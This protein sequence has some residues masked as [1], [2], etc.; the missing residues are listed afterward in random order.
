M[1]IWGGIECTINRVGDQYFNQL[2]YQGHYQ[3]KGDLQLLA[4]LG[5]KKLRYPVLWEKH[6]S[7]S[8]VL[9]WGETEENLIELKARGIEVIAGLVHHGS[10]PE[11]AKINDN[12]FAEKL[13]EFAAQVAIKFPWI[14]YYTPVNEPLTT[15]RFCGLYGLWYPHENNSA[16]FLR[17]LVHECKA[18]IL[19]MQR[20]R[21]INPL[22]KLVYTED[23]G[24]THSTPLLKYQADFE[25]ERKWLSID[26]LCGRVIQGHP[27]RNYLEDNGISIGE[28]DFFVE[29]A[30]FPDILGFNYYIT[31]ERY[32]DE[33]ISCYP[34]VTHGGNACCKYADVEAIRV[35][36]VEIDG[37][38]KLLK[39]AW[40]R[41]KLPIAITE[42]HLYCTREDQL[43]WVNYIMNSANKL[44]SEGVDMLAMTVWSLFGAYGWDHLLTRP[45][46]NYESGVFD[47]SSGSP[48]KTALFPLV[49]NFTTG[50]TYTHPVIK[51]RGWWEKDTRIIYPDQ[52][53]SDSSFFDISCAPILIIGA[54][55]TLGKVFAATCKQRDIRFVTLTRNELNLVNPDQI[56][57]VIK[58]YKPWAI[59]NAAGYVKIDE[60]EIEQENCFLSNTKGPANLASCCKKHQI[61]LLTF[62]S[63]LV[64]DGQKK[65]E[66]IENDQV[67]PL[68][69]YGMSKAQAETEVLKK[70]PDALI[71]RTSA[72]FSP[73][74]NYNFVAHILSSLQKNRTVKVANDVFISPTYVPDLVNKSLDLLID[75][76]RGIWHLANHG[77]V[78]WSDLAY[79]VAFRS[80][81]NSSLLI[82]VSSAELGKPAIR[83]AFS[84]LTSSRGILLPKLDHALDRFFIAS[85]GLLYAS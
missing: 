82:P 39:E 24:K 52:S 48:R 68:N 47:I 40:E 2:D 35:A 72:F 16:S 46:G 76:E 12:N 5:I 26:L 70:D 18:T 17:L 37:A 19:A 30:I 56:E 77:T 74:D 61:K 44:K 43:R 53:C 28:L 3:R 9:N 83:P 57:A 65:T 4:E 11:Y 63:D 7:A 62:S 55:G 59:V 33:H 13:A 20:I 51:G 32:L 38:R 29:N 27:L 6:Q 25:N 69:M 85:K 8:S 21:K 66:Y 45:G 84:A 79:E 80:H 75:N 49:Q 1:E 67:N 15:A 78:C 42:C 50:K 34:A 10:G 58:N 22:A 31:S 81:C 71:I 14:Q 60:A 54:S 23:L 41:Y 73:F 36:A 64:F